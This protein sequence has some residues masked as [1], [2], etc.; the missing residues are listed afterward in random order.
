[1]KNKMSRCLVKLG[2]Q[3]LKLSKLQDLIFNID[4]KEYKKAP[5]GYYCTNISK[6]LY[7]GILEKNS[8]LQYS[9]TPLGKKNISTPYA[10]N[11]NFL[12]NRVKLLEQENRELFYSRDEK[13]IIHITK[14]NEYYF[15]KWE[16]LQNQLSKILINQEG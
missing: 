1:M 5:P 7:L 2:N 10:Q 12:K 8:K 16:N 6:L 13:R 11:I 14:S 9:I 15:R 4:S 3:K